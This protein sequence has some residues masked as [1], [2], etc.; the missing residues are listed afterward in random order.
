MSLLVLG[1]PNISKDV[2][3]C[4]DLYSYVLVCTFH[5]STYQ[6]IPVHACTGIRST[7]RYKLVQHGTW[8]YIQVHTCISLYMSVWGLYKQVHTGSYFDELIW[9][10][11]DPPAWP[12]WKLNICCCPCSVTRHTSSSTMVFT[13]LVLLPPPGHPLS[14]EGGGLGRGSRGRVCCPPCTAAAHAGSSYLPPSLW[15]YNDVVAPTDSPSIQSRIHN[16]GTARQHTSICKPNMDLQIGKP[17]NWR[18]GSI[19]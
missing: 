8:R 15:C 1:Y 10:L 14:W 3:T 7:W 17:P 13:F 2:P 19:S 11:L 16:C 6:Y 9:S 4:I 5:E 18:P 12:A